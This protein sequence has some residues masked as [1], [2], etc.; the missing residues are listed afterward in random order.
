MRYGETCVECWNGKVNHQAFSSSTTFI[1]I[2][3]LLSL[4]LSVNN[5]RK[6]NSFLPSFLQWCGLVIPPLALLFLFSVKKTINYRT[7]MNCFGWA[8]KFEGHFNVIF[9]SF[10]WMLLL[11]CFGALLFVKFSLLPPLTGWWR[12]KFDGARGRIHLVNVKAKESLRRVILQVISRRRRCPLA[13]DY[14]THTC[15]RARE[16]VRT[17]KKKIIEKRLLDFQSCYYDSNG[18]RRKYTVLFSVSHK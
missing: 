2:S 7:Y 5:A 6:K 16:C 4:Y 14:K 17:N 13:V 18:W 3:L 8:A 11:F 15:A 12:R 1:L 10:V 9:F